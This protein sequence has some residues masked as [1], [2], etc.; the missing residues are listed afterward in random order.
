MNK[1]ISRKVRVYYIN[2]QYVYYIDN[3]DETNT[4]K[5]HPIKEKSQYLK[6]GYNYFEAQ[7]E[8]LTTHEDLI[9][10]K[11]EFN[12][13]IN[14]IEIEFGKNK[15]KFEYRTKYSHNDAV[16]RLYK[17]LQT[18]ELKPLN[19]EKIEDYEFIPI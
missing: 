19:M 5:S 6:E 16:F 18:R 3:D 9:R 2:E 4:L 8:F 11:N 12:K 10:Y 13:C 17:Y 14:D 1:I 7:K 15:I